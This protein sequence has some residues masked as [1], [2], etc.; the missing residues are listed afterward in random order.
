VLC[1]SSSRFEREEVVEERPF[2]GREKE[3][4]E[5]AL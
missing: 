3:M 2:Q 1:K 4:L 5:D